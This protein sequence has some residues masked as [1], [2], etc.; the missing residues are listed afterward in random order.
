MQIKY[1]T[2]AFA[3]LVQLINFIETKNTAGAGVR[4]LEKY[5]Q[6]LIKSFM[7][8]K[9]KRICNNATFKKLNLR[10]IYFNDWLIAFSLHENFVLI[11][12][13]LHKS[14]ITE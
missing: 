11:E 1:T 10:C 6:Y 7:N 13:L 5:E 2:D 4:W 8:G 14:R 9:R 3:S 12:A